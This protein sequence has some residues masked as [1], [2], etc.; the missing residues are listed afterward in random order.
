MKRNP[1]ITDPNLKSIL[2]E[3]HKLFAD[4]IVLFIKNKNYY[5]NIEAENFYQLREFYKQQS[6]Q[7]EKIIERT[8]EHIRVLDSQTQTRLSDYLMTTNLLEQPYTGHTKDQLKYL[9]ASH[10]TIIDNLRRLAGLFF[11][12]YHNPSAAYFARKILIEH[13]KMAWMIRSY[14]NT[15]P[16]KSSTVP[17]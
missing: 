3:F 14:L 6:D 7:L 15:P 16:K 12:K 2:E 13:E 9:L 11:N 4:E 8:A 1:T 10:E 5:W 17:D